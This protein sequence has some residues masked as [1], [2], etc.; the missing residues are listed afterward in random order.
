MTEKIEIIDGKE[1][2]VKVLPSDK[3]LQ[4]A[5]VKKRQLFQSMSSGEKFKYFKEVKRKAKK[6]RRK[7]RKR[8]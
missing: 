4:P 1:Y 5:Q 3:R 7:K 2:V 6:N 8:K